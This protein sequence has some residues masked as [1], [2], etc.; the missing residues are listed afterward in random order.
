MITVRDLVDATFPVG[1]A[2]L[3]GA[4]AAGREV[5]WATRPKPSP[6][7][8]AHL[9]G[10]E[11]V[12][13]SETA[14]ANVDER[15][16]LDAA[17][18]E[19]ATL[20]VTAIAFLGT[21]TEEARVAADA[22]GV[23]F[24]HLP[25]GTDLSSLEREA[26][27]LITERRRDL[28]RR[29][30]EFGRRLMELAIAGEPLPAIL[31]ALNDLGGFAVA[32]EG[33]DGRIAAFSSSGGDHARVELEPLLVEGREA[34]L[35][36]LRS[37]AASSPAEPPSAIYPLTAKWSRVVAPVIGR[38]GLLGSVSMIVRGGVPTTEEVALT[39][40]G[41]AACA[42][43][44]A[45]EYATLA[46]RREI[47][48]NVLDE[49]LDGALRSDVSL[50]QQA[51]R[52]GYDL[53]APHA[54]LVARLDSS[55]GTSVARGRDQRWPGLEEIMGRRGARH[56]WRIRNNSAEIVL[57]CTDETEARS[58][59][60][61]LFADLKRRQIDPAVSLSAG[62][63]PVRSGLTGIRKSYGEAKHAVTMGRRLSGT[64]GL[65]RF[66]D[67]GVYRLI[68]AAEPLPELQAFHD[69][70]L[71]ALIEYDAVH[72]GDLV[73]TLNAFF[74]A[75]CGPKEAAALLDVHRNTVLYRM[76]RIR[77]ITKLNLDDA[78]VRLRLHLALCVHLALYKRGD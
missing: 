52:L 67:L 17:V 55:G 50:L 2:L 41:A 8:F 20:N 58:A 70:A 61:T 27:H 64:G 24:L 31:Q 12:L 35:P 43:V 18:R 5:S 65:T 9:K 72:G 42:V 77:E 22:E 34:M 49:V 37:T 4:T 60:T 39:S 56:L 3:A 23:A 29:S 11:I 73:R 21:V 57:A 7:A 40:R 68:Y 51:E 69:E 30:Q 38:D 71:G 28:Q 36:W 74:R 59:L 66:E 13:V 16:T 6:P 44:M 53:Q 75:K 63:G 46:A 26:S 54:V 14:L 76:E 15:M 47:E 32:L 19:L 48:I 45:R 62:A 78:D 25:A 1:T 33:R 10:G